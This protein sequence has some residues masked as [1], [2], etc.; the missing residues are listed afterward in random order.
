MG[1]E[2]DSYADIINW[3]E[4]YQPDP[5]PQVGDIYSGLRAP[6]GGR[7]KDVTSPCQ[8][9]VKGLPAV[10][11]HYTGEECSNLGIKQEDGSVKWPS[12]YN[13]GKCD[14]LGR[15]SWCSGYEFTGQDSADGYICIAPDMFRSG[16]G[17]RDEAITTHLQLVPYTKDEILG[18]NQE[19]DAKGVG[20]CDGLG[21][22]RG[23]GGEGV[24][25]PETMYK[26]PVVCRHYKPWMMGLGAIKPRPMGTA[27]L[28][29]R[30]I[31]DGTA[32]DPLSPLTR[33]LPFAFRVYNLRASCQK[34]AYWDQDFG[35]DFE[36]DCSGG[37]ASMFLPEDPL[38][39]CT[40]ASDASVPYKTI[41]DTWLPN[42]SDTLQYV[43][44]EE[45]GIVCNGAK[46]ECPCYTGKWIY[47]TDD[48]MRDGMR[49]TAEQIM[50][51]R[52]YMTM[53]NSK[54][55]YDNAFA[56]KSGPLGITTSDLYTFDKWEKLGSFVAD[57]VMK[58]KRIYQNFPIGLNDQAFNPEIHLTKEVIVYPKVN[59]KTGTLD[60]NTTVFPTLVRDLSGQ[61]FVPHL[62]VVYPYICK[63][64]WDATLGSEYDSG[65][66]M[67]I[68]SC[69]T[70]SPEIAAF[71]YTIKEKKV[72]VL[73]L[74][75]L[76]APINFDVFKTT[77]VCLFPEKERKILNE[78]IGCFISS[79]MEEG[80]NNI[81]IANGISNEYGYFVI[82]PL[83][84]DYNTTTKLAIICEWQFGEYEVVIREVASKFYGGAVIQNSFEFKYGGQLY[85]PSLPAQFSPSAKLSGKGIALGG[86]VHS[87]FPVYSSESRYGIDFTYSLNEYSVTGEKAKVSDWVSIGPTGYIWAEIDNIKLSYLFG[88]GF[89]NAYMKRNNSIEADALCWDTSEDVVQL[90]VVCPKSGPIS[91]SHLLPNCVVLRALNPMAFFK[92]DW[93]LYVEYS[94]RVLETFRAPQDDTTSTAIWPSDSIE[95]QR[96][97][98]PPFSFSTT[99]NSFEI[100]HIRSGTIP[101][102]VFIQDKD[103][104]VQA[105]TATKML[106]DIPITKC[107]NVE[108]F[109]RYNA[110]ATRYNLIPNRGFF[111][112]RGA[113]RV[114]DPCTHQ[115][116]PVCGDHG[117]HQGPGPMW[118]PFSSC[119]EYSYYNV[120]NGPN[121]CVQWIEDSPRPDFRYSTVERYQASVEPSGSALFDCIDGWSYFYSVANI[122]NV[123][124]TGYANIKAR[125]DVAMYRASEWALPPFG[126]DGREYTERWLSQDYSLFYDCSVSPP[127]YR[128]EYMP[129]VFD[130]KTLFASFNAFEK[131]E[132]LDCF[133]STC[134]LNYMKSNIINER[135][136]TDNVSRFRFEDLFKVRTH[137][138][139]MYPLPVYITGN[140]NMT[141]RYSFNDV[142][143][144][145]VAWAWREYWNN[146]ERQV[147]GD[148]DDVVTT[149]LNF[150]DFKRPG[151][152]FDYDKMEHRL[153]TGEG[154]VTIIF[155][156]PTISLEGTSK[157]EDG[158]YNG[159]SYPEISIAG[160]EARRFEVFYDDYDKEQVEW[161]DEGGDG[162]SGSSGGDENPSIYE[163]TSGPDWIQIPNLIVDAEA[164]PVKS[165]DRKIVVGRVGTVE[166]NLWYNRGLSALIS[167][168]RLKYFPYKSDIQPI[169]KSQIHVNRPPSIETASFS[170]WYN[171]GL[172]AQD[173]VFSYSGGRC[174]TNMKW[175]GCM[176]VKITDYLEVKKGIYCNPSVI[177]SECGIDDP[178]SCP[179]L[180][181]LLPTILSR[182]SGE[183]GN[184][185]DYALPELYSV[186]V[187]L[188]RSPKRVLYSSPMIRA[189]FTLFNGQHLMLRKFDDGAC[190]NMFSGQ[191]MNAVEQIK[192]WERKYTVSTGNFGDKN[193][194]GP[195]SFE[196]RGYDRSF[197][198]AGQYFPAAGG[199]VPQ[200]IVYKDKMTMVGAGKHY[201]SDV[202]LALTMNNLMDKEVQEQ[203]K[204]YKRAC[205]DDPYDTITYTTFIPQ[206]I[207]QFFDA[208]K[209]NLNYSACEGV[210]TFVSEKLSWNKHAVLDG[211]VPGE[212]WQ[213]GGHSYEWSGEFETMECWLSGGVLYDIYKTRFMHKG[214]G[215]DVGDKVYDPVVVYV[216]WIK[217]EYYSGALNLLSD[218]PKVV[219]VDNSGLMMFDKWG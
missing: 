64:P 147:V 144:G 22:G 23:A 194:D 142:T 49:V 108:I 56:A 101:I 174:I 109:Y 43:L 1:S 153:I 135:V 7:P 36:M 184:G 14:Y 218:V 77:K 182:S 114:V 21:M 40:C 213:P 3:Y 130:D 52:F 18:Y 131:S 53:W 12:G 105:A 84:L 97:I 85:S 193:P 39:E 178:P 191:Y 202:P 37:Y 83:Q 215:D 151:Y 107:R 78:K 80:K 140:V 55:A 208:H 132:G 58:G 179:N 211:Y 33:Y 196:L 31:Y 24:T 104:R 164:S 186:D 28:E 170:V 128:S 120:H 92:A 82:G 50:E 124:F 206:N 119:T 27:V 219:S 117:A 8:Y 205:E 61:A 74:N 57:S 13:D 201:G 158:V 73:N 32:S 171:T 35:S 185:Y 106:F 172:S 47:C 146:I 11:K 190:V 160:G 161:M 157:N 183:S 26:L 123:V 195:E 110:P 127:V 30:D 163:V 54:K 141:K 176:G 116:I 10:C 209:I 168:D 148:V 19:E 154:A 181:D 173:V 68:A 133:H 51:L 112:W 177:I 180:S 169:P 113:D 46:P 122:K 88:L 65:E 25:N 17:K 15:R 199:H 162:S 136:V 63:D 214:H 2:T 175:Y 69:K 72:Y 126:N 95:G 125:V 20:R 207:K 156:A 138:W 9:W 76:K 210:C 60:S 216:G 87:I 91:R 5:H 67:E 100:E 192:V 59:S 41:T 90:Q 165:D 143:V 152:Y 166:T 198:N 96:F 149:F 102:M 155:R 134:M 111:D 42:T 4:D 48:N 16:L 66:F 200:K 203:E 145:G 204:L 86:E 167:K 45:N 197:K 188:E 29:G 71:G 94:Y 44:T 217:Q 99:N 93:T 79:T 118:F 6:S 137:S 150:V 81:Y 159:Y 75:K 34:C 115:R 121:F 139:C 103:T 98:N 62:D 189:K 89:T 212:F 129:L 187:G 70:V 38:T